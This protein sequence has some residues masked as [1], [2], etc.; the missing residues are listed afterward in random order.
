MKRSTNVVLTLLV[1]AM[2]AFGCSQQSQQSMPSLGG[3]S[4][5]E[6]SADGTTAV[7][8]E[9]PEK[10]DDR[11]KQDATNPAVAGHTPTRTHHG[12]FLPIPWMGGY[13]GGRSAPPA[14]SRVATVASHPSGTSQPGNG[15]V[16]G[17]F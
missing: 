14:P 8:G 12:G 11:N 7:N 17:G 3:G 13:R 6:A 9:N 16:H 10:S 2:A 15:V 1:P 4:F 5:S